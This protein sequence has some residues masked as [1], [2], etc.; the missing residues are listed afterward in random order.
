M[1]KLIISLKEVNS[2]LTEQ[3]VQLKEEVSKLQ[4]EI[5]LLKEAYRAGD[6]HALD[7]VLSE[8]SILSKI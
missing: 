4:N 2:D 1:Y 3:N 7:S 5:K 8:V 6:S